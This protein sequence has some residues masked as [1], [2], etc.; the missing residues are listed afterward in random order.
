[1]D[2]LP[3]PARWSSAVEEASWIGERLSAFDSHVATSVVSAGFEAYARVLHPAEEPGRGGRLVRWRQVAAWSGVALDTARRLPSMKRSGSRSASMARERP[4]GSG[5]RQVALDNGEGPI[6]KIDNVAMARLWHG[7]WRDEHSDECE[8]H[9]TLD[10]IPRYRVYPQGMRSSEVASQAGVN[11]QT[12]RYY[13]RRGILPEPKRSGRASIPPAEPGAEPLA[14]EVTT[15]IA[16]RH[17]S[18]EA[19]PAIGVPAAR[20]E[21]RLWPRSPRT[22]SPWVVV[23]RCR[24]C[25]SWSSQSPR[26]RPAGRSAGSGCTRRPTNAGAG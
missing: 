21:L 11:V 14:S 10:L 5:A 2:P 1:M 9:V 13:E 18:G 6:L 12:L 26:P 7:T 20:S 22:C 15:L 19:C 25:P 17:P 3:L 8:G 24:R 16:R 4:A 23:L